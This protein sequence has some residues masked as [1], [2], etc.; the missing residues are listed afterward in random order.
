MGKA[1]EIEPVST[2]IK[3]NAALIAYLAGDF[4][5]AAALG[6]AAIGF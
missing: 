5:R 2:I 3:T 4:D 1:L 6:S